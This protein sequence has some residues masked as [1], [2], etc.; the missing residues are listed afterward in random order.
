AQVA[1]SVY[2]QVEELA[3]AVRQYRDEVEFD[4][5]RLEEVEERLELIHRLQ[6]KYGDTLADVLAFA[7]RVEGELHSITHSD[8]R[9]EE[10]RAEEQQLL[11]EMGEVGQA[12]SAA[13][14]EAADRLA[15]GI[16][17][18]LADLS[19]GSARF[20]VSMARE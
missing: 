4:P 3:R 11:A 15:A 9:A 2:Y 17:A 20:V 14:R 5:D 10:L 12:L 19:M 13:R 8:E 6:R 7:E 18:Q 16:E 1:E